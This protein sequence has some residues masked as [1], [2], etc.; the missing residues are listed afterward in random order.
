MEKKI[1]VNKNDIQ[2]VQP[3]GKLLVISGPSG[4][5]KTEVSL[6][7]RSLG[8]LYVKS[9]SATTRKIRNGEIDGVDYFFV[10]C[11]EFE[12]MNKSGDLLETTCY[13][14]N[15]YGTPKKFVENVLEEGKV[16]ILVIDVLGAIQIKKMFPDAALCFLNAESLDAIEKRLRNR[17]SDSE[18][19]IINRLATAKSE[20]EAIDSFDF[21]VYN[22]EGK[23]E[24]AAKEIDKVIRE[25]MGL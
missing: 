9:V 6:I 19:A 11:D 25:M 17:N 3:K 8:D 16:V 24:N 21:V 12:E 15:H 23:M 4:V 5:G 18:E 13:N 22:R 1:D 2:P 20:L 7:L 14:G 10:T